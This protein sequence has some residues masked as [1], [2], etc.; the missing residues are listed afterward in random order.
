MKKQNKQYIILVFAVILYFF[1]AFTSDEKTNWR[2]HYRSD[3]KD[4]Y[5]TKA[6]T[7]LLKDSV[8][9][10]NIKPSRM[11]AYEIYDSLNIDII[12]NHLMIINN[13]LELDKESVKSIY[14]GALK[15]GTVF[16][17]AENF[18]RNLKDTLDFEMNYGYA[19]I[20]IEDIP[21]LKENEF[22]FDTLSVF[23]NDKEGQFSAFELNNSF[24]IYDSTSIEV[25]AY[26]EDGNAIFMKQKIGL[27]AIYLLSTPKILT[28]VALLNDDNNKLIN[29]IIKELPKGNYIRTEYYALGRKGH[30]S[31]LRVILARNGLR[32]AVQLFLILI[33]IY[34]IFEIK[35]EQRAIPE[36]TPPSNDSLKFVNTLGQ[37]YLGQ[38]D[39]KNILIKRKRYLLNHIKNKYNINLNKEEIN[40]ELELLSFRSGIKE[41]NIKKLFITLDREIKHSITDG[42]FIKVNELID[43]FYSKEI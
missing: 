37:L 35:R 2:P 22:E 6:L 4:P 27:G 34:L 33:F 17:A 32:E 15:G 12:S 28:N 11:T 38:K 20:Q 40:E 31:T 19:S 21:N 1:L 8:M 3:S 43:D 30:A 18:S 7:E 10:V 26:N 9:K 5:G 36:L 16:L 29:E 13:R 23:I 14:T 41:E 39:N 42:G 25:L 24:D